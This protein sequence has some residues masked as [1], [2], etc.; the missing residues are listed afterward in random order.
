VQ[1][2]TLLVVGGRD[3]LVREFNEE[4]GRHLRC[5]HEL[6]V[7]AGATH[8]FEEAGTLDAVAK[9]AADWF[10]AHLGPDARLAQ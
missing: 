10:V 5:P 6:L 4:A 1:A 3:T 9:L 7:V 8:L 2:P